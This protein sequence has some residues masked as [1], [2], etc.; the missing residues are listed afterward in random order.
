M[1]ADAKRW[2]WRW[3]IASVDIDGT[4][5]M[6]DPTLARRSRELRLGPEAEIDNL[7]TWLD[8]RS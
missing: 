5:R 3:A 1:D 8:T 4:V 6:L 2:G 7:L